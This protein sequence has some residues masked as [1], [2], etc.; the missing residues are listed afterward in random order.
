LQ[1]Q[2]INRITNDAFPKAVATWS[3]QEQEYALFVPTLGNDRPDTGF[4]LHVDRLQAAPD[5]SP[6]S[7]RKGFPVGAVS[8]FFGG[9]IVFG[10]HTGNQDTAPESERGLFVMS[11]KRA[12]GRVLVD[13]VLKDGPTPTSIYRSAWSAFGDPQTQ[14][15]V[16]YV[17]IWMLTTGN[18]KITMR[19]Y[20][21]F[22]LQAV[23]ERTYFAQPPDAASLAT[24]DKSVLSQAT[25][26]DERLVPLRFSVAHQGCSWFCFELET[27][28]D[29]IL[30]GWE[31]GFTSKGTQVVMG[32]RA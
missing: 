13:D 31:Y 29:L 1:D 7:T 24:L 17:T 6:W 5:A 22:S 2:F 18:Q 11:G 26:R 19:H 28:E 25:Y 32:V 14:K 9:A 8:T 15:Q 23:E 10:H 20:K 12:L 4:I 30:V 16:A 21:D 27:Q 3:A